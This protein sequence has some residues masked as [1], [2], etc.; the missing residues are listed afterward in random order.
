MKPYDGY[1]KMCARIKPRAASAHA[2]LN[3]SF[4]HRQEGLELKRVSN[5]SL[6]QQSHFVLQQGLCAEAWRFPSFSLKQ[7]HLDYC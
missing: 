4:R 5:S 3:P 1:G 7:T 2:V 6:L